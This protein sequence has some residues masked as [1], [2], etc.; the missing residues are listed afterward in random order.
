MNKDIY[1][2]IIGKVH[3]ALYNVAGEVFACVCSDVTTYSN[4]LFCFFVCFF[5]VTGYVTG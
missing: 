1:I 3:V 2:Y 4:V 5:L